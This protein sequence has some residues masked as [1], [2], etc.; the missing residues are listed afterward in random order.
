M[1]NVNVLPDGW[2]IAGVVASFLVAVIAL[3][4][5]VFTYKQTKNMQKREQKERILRE[6]IEWVLDVKR[7]TVPTDIDQVILAGKRKFEF[8]SISLADA[9]L[10]AEL[11]KLRALE[12]SIPVVN[13]L[14]NVWRSA[15]FCSQ[16]AERI[17][18]Y[19]PSDQ[20]RKIWSK[21]TLDIVIRIDQLEEQ[22]KLN[23]E[24]LY[25]GQKKLLEDISACFKVLVKIEATS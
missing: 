10:K 19:R 23:D 3:G 4:L 25:H 8:I 13:E 24:E 11:M 5:G 7:K 12:N 22:K 1:I 6:I 18:G 9:M 14:D 15:F 2:T 17:M 21:A 16:L 20:Q